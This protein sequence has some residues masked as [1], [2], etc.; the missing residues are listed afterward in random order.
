VSAEANQAD[1]LND[2]IETAAEGF[3]TYADIT[4]IS[5]MEELQDDLDDPDTAARFKAMFKGLSGDARD[6]YRGKYK[7]I[8][9]NL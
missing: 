7:E 6:L 2:F 1:G 4:T 3:R 5:D 8:L 9:A